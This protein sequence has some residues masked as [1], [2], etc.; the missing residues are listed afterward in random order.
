MGSCWQ[1]PLLVCLPGH[2]R[3]LHQLMSLLY[4]LHLNQTDSHQMTAA[5]GRQLLVI[6]CVQHGPIFS[7]WD[8]VLFFLCI[9]FKL[10][11]RCIFYL[12]KHAPTAGLLAKHRGGR[13]AAKSWNIKE[14]E[15][16]QS[17]LRYCILCEWLM[18]PYTF[19]SH[20]HATLPRLL[21]PVS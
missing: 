6:L 18:M 3:I 9:V 19:S 15:K 16:K 10:N 1:P 13:R 4:W 20:H 12:S 7:I 21:S 11:N 14:K 5:A 8:I 17:R 2:W